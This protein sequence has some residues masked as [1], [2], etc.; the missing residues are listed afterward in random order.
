MLKMNLLIVLTRLNSF[1]PKISFTYEKENNS[2]LPFLHVLFFRNGTHLDTTAYQKDT[3]NDLYLHWDPFAPASWK[4]ETLRTLVN[5]AYL[6]FSNKE[7][8]CK[9]LVYLRS[10]HLKKNGYPLWTIK[11]LMKKIEKSQKQTK[12]TKISM[13]KQPNPQEQR[14]HSL[15]LFLRALKVKLLLRFYYSSIKHSNSYEISI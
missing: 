4:R 3:H 9:E 14:V 10:V 6:V 13:T 12:V 1:H 5:R 11:Q 15:L 8:L 7:S 2:Q